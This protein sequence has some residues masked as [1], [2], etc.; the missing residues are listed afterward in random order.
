[1][2]KLPDN[3]FI[4]KYGLKVRLVNEN[5]ADFIVSLRSDPNKTKYM[6][7][8]NHE[9][10]SQIRWMKEYKKRE[11]EGLD[12]YFIYSSLN[13]K[14]IGVNRLSHINCREKTAVTASWITIG[15]LIYE[16]FLMQLI[17]NEIAFNLLEIN[18]LKGQIH[19]KNNKLIRF[20]E[21]FD[22]KFE[23]NGTDFYHTITLK[24]DFQKV[25]DYRITKLAL[26]SVVK[27]ED[28]VK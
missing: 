2:K 25:Y 26:Q 4:E 16:P 15:G 27:F 23:D 7:T 3:F 21:L 17:L 19:I 24:N 28:R 5:D 9:I 14:P 11:K 18:I 22:A 10:E 12:Y 8:L 1:M 20:F 6:V 13:N